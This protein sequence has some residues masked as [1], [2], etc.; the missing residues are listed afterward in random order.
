MKKYQCRLIFCLLKGLKLKVQCTILVPISFLLVRMFSVRFNCIVHHLIKLC[1]LRFLL[2]L[3]HIQ[4]SIILGA[5]KALL[6][7][8]RDKKVNKT[9]VRVEVAL[10]KHQLRLDRDHQV[11]KVTPKVKAKVEYLL[12]I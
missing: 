4:V 6:K 12:Q 2:P 11:L 3:S 9:R 10:E 1:L 5:I 7:F 8:K